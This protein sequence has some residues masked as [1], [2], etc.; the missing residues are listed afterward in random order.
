MTLKD[1]IFQDKKF[2]KYFFKYLM[3]KELK[4]SYNP[5]VALVTRKK[6]TQESDLGDGN[7][8]HFV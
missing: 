7:G 4:R 8:E 5:V 1:L 2:R 6:I 3:M